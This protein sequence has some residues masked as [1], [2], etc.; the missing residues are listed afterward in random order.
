MQSTFKSFP[1]SF[2]GNRARHHAR[3][4]VY[5]ELNCIFFCPMKYLQA[6]EKDRK[7]DLIYQLH[8]LKLLHPHCVL[9]CKLV[10]GIL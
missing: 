5:K 9:D 10:G 6:S 8:Y 2:G 3:H 1:A 4:W 7:M